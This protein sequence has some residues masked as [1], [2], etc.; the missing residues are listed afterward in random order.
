MFA[1][2]KNDQMLKTNFL[3]LFVCSSVGVYAQVG[4]NNQNPKATLD[5]QKSAVAT[6]P[7][8][9]LTPRMTGD[10]LKNKDALYGVDQNSAVVFVTAPS[11]TTTTKTSNVTTSGFYYYNNG[12]SKWVGLTMPKFFYMPSISFD[13]TT[14]GTYQKDLYQLYYNQFT[15]PPVKST[16]S[17][18][19]VPVLG[20]NDL[21]YYITYY[22]TTVFSNVTIDANGLMKYDVINNASDSSF[23]NIV[24]VVK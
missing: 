1:I 11:T 14:M 24:F 16:G 15:S 3:L 19:K 12:I 13:T 23:I 5:I 21:E 2:Q 9:L 10:E 8:G 17:L 22:D 18:G 6:L 4:I 7:D 20:K